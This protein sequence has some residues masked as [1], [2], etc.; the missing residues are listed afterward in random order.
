MTPLLASLVVGPV[1]FDRPAWLLLIPI[2]GLLTWWIGRRSLAGL[3]GSTRWIA[4]AVRLLVIA[5]LAGALAEPQFR[6]TSDDVA[7]TLVIDASRSI[8]LEEQRA[9]DGYVADAREINARSDDRLGVLT[10]GK[11]AYVQSLPSERVLGVDRTFVGD[12]DAT[13]LAAGV[14]LAVAVAPDDAANR[15][16][17]ASDGNETEGS[18]LAA[19]EAA[20]AAGIPIDVLPIEYEYPAEVIV[21]RILAPASARADETVNLSVVINATSPVV[22]RLLLTAQGQPVDLSPGEEGLGSVERLQRG[23]NVISVQLTAD[24]PGPQEYEA[25]FEP[26]ARL[27]EDGDRLATGERGDAISQNNRST[28]VTFVAAE[29]TALIVSE[30]DAESRAMVEAL[31]QS[32]I[33]TERIGS[34]RFP[35]TLVEL[36]RYDAIVLMNQPAYNFTQAQQE[37]M[38]RYVNDSGGGLV[39]TGGPQ[40]F[41]AGGWIGSPLEDALPVRLDPPQKRQM[42]RGALAL[43]IHSVEAPRGVYWGKQV[44][45]AAVDALSAEDLVGITEYQ[46]FAGQADWVYGIAEKGDGAAVKRAINN[47]TFGDMQSFDPTLRLTLQGL[48]AVDA[49]QKHCVIISD[50]DPA[51]NRGILRSFRNAGIT[52]ST[53]GIFPHSTADFDTLRRI[54]D[55]TGGTFYSV[56]QRAQLPTL[57][58]IFIKEAQTVR[59]T[60][61]WEGEPF[62]PTVIGVPTETMRGITGLP[63]I[64]GYVVTADRQGLSLVTTRALRTQRRG[65]QDATIE[66]PISAQW[67]YGLGRVVAFTSDA[68]T[69]W[70]SAWV[71]WE[72]YRQ[73]WEQ[74]VRWAMRPSGSDNVRVLTQTDGSTT[75]VVVEALDDQGERLNFADF[76]ARVAGP[77]GEGRDLEMTQI[78]PG[79]YRGEFEAADAGSYVVSL[80]YRA[81]GRTEG[82]TIEGSVQAAVTRPFADEFRALESNETLLRRV[83]DAT[84]GRVLTRSPTQDDLWRREGLERPVALRPIWL[85]VSMAGIALF[86]ADVGIRRVRLEPARLAG[87]IASL[88]GRAERRARDDAGVESLRAAREKARA[89]MQA[90]ESEQRSRKF[91]AGEDREESGGPVA[92]SGEAEKPAEAGLKKQDQASKAKD[93]A[94]EGEGEG[95]SRLMRAKRRARDGYKDGG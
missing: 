16:V 19:A 28:A 88:F 69:R 39:M 71:G 83:A 6:R 60:L 46:G 75:E 23:K 27:D 91:E 13:D 84:G 40:S 79:R 17:L 4:L 2:L 63:P 81:P 15:I 29:G 50:G 76:R 89:R 8:P 66:D 90:S 26:I 47:L 10:V 22:G 87:S 18:L 86:L 37:L 34:A 70:A 74:H 48:Q 24:R 12:T 67:Q 9:V 80:L 33:A 36:N 32:G 11:E 58:K 51:L 42:P 53:V 30:S 3:G 57:P 95:L 92:L 35:P 94:D 78:G 56:N 31:A 45:N 52:I 7:V 25:V 43:V 77:G 21:E 55:A 54:A 93:A 49:G 62:P 41:G 14:R 1:Q 85:A 38:R 59:R 44:S 73:F 72:G 20:R 64:T 68:S 82:Q 5:L 61:I 65:G